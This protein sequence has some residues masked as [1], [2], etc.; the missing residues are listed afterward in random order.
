M[1]RACW[2]TEDED[3]GFPVEKAALRSCDLSVL[4]VGGKWQWLVRHA[5]RD[6][7]EGVARGLVDTKNATESMALK[8]V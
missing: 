7:T 4:H 1:T 5:D 8:L 3:G 2:F 6:V